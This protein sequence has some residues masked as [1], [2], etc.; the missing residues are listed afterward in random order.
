MGRNL[1]VDADPFAGLGLDAYPTAGL[2]LG[3]DA[4]ARPDQGG[5]EDFAGDPDVSALP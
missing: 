2:D 1:D 5:D 4:V 3:T